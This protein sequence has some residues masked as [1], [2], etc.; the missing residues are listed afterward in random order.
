MVHNFFLRSCNLSPV[1]AFVRNSHRLLS[2]ERDFICNQFLP[3]SQNH[4]T[5]SLRNRIPNKLNESLY[6]NEQLH[7]EASSHSSVS[8]FLSEPEK[9]REKALDDY[10]KQRSIQADSNIPFK[11]LPK[12]PRVIPNFKS[13][14]RYHL[15]NHIQPYVNLTKP[16]LTILVTISSICSYAISPYSASLLKLFL[17]TIGTA[18]CSSSANAIN[19]GREPEFDSKMP[20]TVGRPVVRGLITPFQAYN[21]ALLTGVMGFTTLFFGVN[22]TVAL[23]GL[24]NIILYSWI[25]TSL[26]RRSIINTWIGAIVGAIPPLMGWAVSSSL[27]DPG[28]WCLAAL[29]YSWQ[30]PHFNSLS[31]N[32]AKQYKDAGYVMT[33]AEYPKLNARVALRYSLL[34]IP[35]CFGLSFYKITDWFFCVDSLIPNTLLAFLAYKFWNQQKQ[36]YNSKSKPSSIAINVANI[37]AKNLFWASV[38]HLPTILILAMA[39][40]KGQWEALFLYLGL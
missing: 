28:A 37:H 7:R 3:V 40:K 14:L 18:L 16:N 6:S 25:Y 26:K 36:N 8:D 13:I 19:M 39:H 23:L 24:T 32:L 15:K 38:W 30:F 2:T 11:V 34:M 17:L 21:F 33:A 31:H 22:G 29:L 9:H 1:S 10:T 35:L 20:R 4:L 12:T 5:N 27:V